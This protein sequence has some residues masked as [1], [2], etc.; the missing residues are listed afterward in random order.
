MHRLRRWLTLLEVRRHA[1]PDAQWH[2]T[3]KVLPLL[4]ASSAAERA[5]L[6]LLATQ[7]IHRK[8]FTGIDG[9]E[10]TLQKKII[11]AAQAC[12]EILN[13]GIES[14][15]GWH[16]IIVYPGAFRVTREVQDELGLV[17]DDSQ[18]NSGESWV[19][20]P[21]ILSWDDVERD[22]FNLRPG[23]N[24]VLHEFAHK[25][26]A[27]NGRANGMPPLHP[28]MPIEAWTAS[29]SEAFE[30]LRSYADSESKINHYAATN[31]AEFFAVLTEYFFT[32]PQLVNNDYPA[33][34][35]QLKQY[36]RQDPLSRFLPGK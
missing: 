31:P 7:F 2:E 35:N 26:D 14:Y 36:Y 19:Q 20:G 10:T 25:L 11:I 8:S 15:S 16:E 33:V 3:I 34:Y 5:K 18:I 6:R 24:V 27:L 32:A 13:L 17:R 4:Q 22:S 12:L 23:H 29:L 28:N 9:L 21:V 1:V 30:K